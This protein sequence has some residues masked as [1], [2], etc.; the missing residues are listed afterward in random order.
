MLSGCRC[1][2]SPRVWR[3]LSPGSSPVRGPV[4]PTAPSLRAYAAARD[5]LSG[6]GVRR[7]GGRWTPPGLFRA[8][9]ASLAP[10]TALA[11]ALANFR[12]YGI[13]EA[14]AMPRVLVALELDLQA[15]A[16][17]T[18]G[19]RP[20][21]PSRVPP[22]DANR[23][24]APDPEPGR[25]AVTQRPSA[26]P[27]SP[28]LEA[29]RVPSAADPSGTNL[30]RLPVASAAR[31][32]DAP[33]LASAPEHYSALLHAKVLDRTEAAGVPSRHEPQTRRPAAARTPRRSANLVGD[34]RASLG[35]LPPPLR[36]LTGY[37][38]RAIA[39]WEAG[40]D[41]SE[42]SRQRMLETRRLEKALARV[43]SPRASRL[44]RG[45][46]PR[47]PWTEAPRG[48]RARRGGSHLAHGLRARV[49]R[50]A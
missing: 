17:L 37:S 48:H 11:E 29:L 2:L 16:D 26:A 6:E 49:G 25:E 15:V 27:P 19:R 9:Y 22:P 12:H 5:L 41:L 24:L 23:S 8:V 13:P 46:Q 21:D 36:R 1:R 34:V 39:A 43:M 31:K 42:A 38:E 40:R 47:V 44:A 20:A 30:A 32:P 3:P 45:A 28:G 18:H 33:A 50:A 35:A 10:E 4:S 14:D 7:H